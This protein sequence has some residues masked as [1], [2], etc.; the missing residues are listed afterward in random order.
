MVESTVLFFPPTNTNVCPRSTFFLFSPFY[1]LFSLPAL[2]CSRASGNQAGLF[3]CLFTDREKIDLSAVAHIRPLFEL[4]CF[5]SPFVWI[6]TGRG[7]W[8]GTRWMAD[9]VYFVLASFSFRFDRGNL[10]QGREYLY[11]SSYRSLLHNLVMRH[12]LCNL[13]RHGWERPVA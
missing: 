5:C 3:E 12:L 11:A 2:R 13:S 1:F 9:G 8:D 7:S 4:Y 6:F 10:Y